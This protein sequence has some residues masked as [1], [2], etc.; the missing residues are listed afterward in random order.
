V[1]LE[2]SCLIERNYIGPWGKQVPLVISIKVVSLKGT[3]EVRIRPPPTTHIW[4][5]FRHMPELELMAEPYV[6]DHA[7]TSPPVIAWILAF[8]KVSHR[9]P[10]HPT[11][12]KVI[13]F[14][15]VAKMINNLISLSKTEI[16][17]N[18]KA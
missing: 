16:R 11:K 8:L 10:S 5:S 13:S 15:H 14:K 2:V 12:E 3:L 18:E 9:S 17:I 7:I 6:G 1:N 4:F